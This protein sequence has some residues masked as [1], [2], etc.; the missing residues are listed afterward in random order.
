MTLLPGAESGEADRLLL[1]TQKITR[2]LEVSDKFTTQGKEELGAK[3]RGEV[4]IV[5]LTGGTLNLRSSTTVLSSESGQQY[6]FVT[7]Q[8]QIKPLTAANVA[9]NPDVGHTAEVEAVTP[10]EGSNIT[11][12]E[13]LEI[14]NQVFGKKPEQLYARV[15][16]EV[17]GGNSRF[18]S[19][20]TQQDFDEAQKELTAQA[21]E[22]VRSSLELDGLVVPEGGWQSSVVEFSP[23]K[24]VGTQTPTFVARVKVDLNLVAFKESGV[25]EVLR[26]RLEQTLS[27][28]LVLQAS[29]L[30]TVEYKV[31]ALDFASTRLDASA[32][33][34]SKA[35]HRV[36][37]EDLGQQLKGKSK[38]EAGEII[39]NDDAVSK[40]EIK[41]E[42]GWV[43]SL[44]WISQRIN[45][46]LSQ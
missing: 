12:G 21:V 44:P 40:V 7:D 42:P 25:R 6:K 33:Y 36:D 22:Q 4:K 20:I 28:N 10:G 35:S 2:Q 46:R 39:L 41:L 17:T 3:A 5:N 11:K 27:P 9:T 19:V 34:T 18:V 15:S 45:I 30:D 14:S 31:P 32:A 8:T 23:E 29:E 1:P 13:R 38:V 26:R 43:P 37:T 16:D 24:P